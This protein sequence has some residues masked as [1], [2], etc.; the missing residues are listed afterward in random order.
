MKKPRAIETSQGITGE[1]NTRLYDEMMRRL[2]GRGWLETGLIIKE[3][4]ISGLALEVGPGPGYLGLEWLKK[5]SGTRLNGLDI[6]EDML[7]LARK[8]AAQ[9]G[10]SDR[11][12]YIGGDARKMPFEDRRFDA[13]FTNGSLHEWAYPEE[14]LNEI[15]RVL[16]PGGRYIISDLRRDVIAP[17]KWFL[18]V[19]TG[20]KEMRAGLITSLNAAYTLYE[21]E[22]ML[23]RTKLQGWQVNK[24][25][26]GIVISGKKTPG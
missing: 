24:N 15:S 7:A 22:A 17:V 9:Y 5:T 20:P 16:K 2:R 4:I 23:S 10:L 1:L 21:V 14:I 11:V 25:P 12:E 18:W 26:L 6:S 13:V 8:N 3:G 19:I